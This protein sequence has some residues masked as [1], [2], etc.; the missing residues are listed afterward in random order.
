MFSL[1]VVVE[2]IIESGNVTSPLSDRILGRCPVNDIVDSNNNIIVKSGEIIEETHIEDINKLSLRSLKIRSVL[3]CETNNGI[4]AKC[5]GRDLARGTA[6]NIGEAVGIIAAQS[7]GEPGTQL[8]MRT[9]H[10]GGAASASVEQSSAS[11]P[12]DG[13]VKSDNFK[14]ITD[15][16]GNK[17]L[18]TRNAKIKICLDDEEKFSLNIPFGSR[19]FFENGENVKANQLLADWDPYTLPIIAEKDGIIKYVD[20]KQG[21]S[22]RDAVDDTTG[23]SS[24]IVIDW[25]QNPKSKNFKPSINIVKTY[26]DEID[27]EDKSVISYPMSI[28]TIL[29]AEDGSEVKAG[30]VVARIPKE[31]SKTKDITGGLPRVAELFEARKPKDPAI[32]SEIDGKISFGKDFKNKRRLIITS[33][34]D[35][36]TFEILIPRSKYLNVQEGDFVKR[37]DILVEG[38]PVPHDILRI[39]G[40]EELARYLVREVQSVYKL[41]GVYIND[42]HIETIARQMLQKVLIK[43][44]G[45]SNLIA[46]EQI[47]RR[48]LLKLNKLL[49][50][51]NKKIIK[52]EPVLLG[53]TKASLQTNSFI[54]AASFQETTKVLTDAAT[55]GKVDTLNGLKENVIVGR[56]VPAGTGHIKNKWNKKALEDDN[57]FLSDQEKIEPSETQTNQ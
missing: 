29:S 40:I 50:D 52:Y 54:S 1:G 16:T 51:E 7:I 43:D 48:D 35:E 23:I 45:D 44:P 11:S 3:T 14:F 21:V 49:S 25:S 22:F 15:E 47:Q 9:F 6:V 17:I 33:I 26:E 12:I 36:E 56:L 4:C 38:T 32:M 2:E 28:D 34:E 37:G 13:M 55:L 20:L 18:L 30:Q 5:Y 31:S 19:I 10:I 57:K 42:K 8:T 24:K 46:G 53:I 27:A 41:Q 39:L